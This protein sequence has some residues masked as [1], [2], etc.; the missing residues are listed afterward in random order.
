[1]SGECIYGSSGII[2]GLPGGP[3]VYPDVLLEDWKSSK[4]FKFLG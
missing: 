4:K 3:D 2:R 1:M